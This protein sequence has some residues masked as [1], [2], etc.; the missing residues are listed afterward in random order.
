[1][2]R[3][4]S[5]RRHP[6]RV[7]LGLALGLAVVIIAVYQPMLGFDFVSFDDINNVVDNPLLQDSLTPESAFSSFTEAGPDGLWTPL[8][9]VSYLA[10]RSLFGPGPFGFH[11]TNLL[12]F[13]AACALFFLVLREMTG[14]TVKSLLAAALFALHPLRVESVAWITE[15]K[16]CLLLLFLVLSLAAYHRWIRTG[17]KEWYAGLI[18]CFLLGLLSKPTMVMLPFLLLALDFWPQGRIG[19]HGPAPPATW[20]RLVMEKLPLLAL[21]LVFSAVTLRA[22]EGNL[23]PLPLPERLAMA[24]SSPIIYLGKTAWPAGLHLATFRPVMTPAWWLGLGA[25]AVLAGAAW[26]SFRQRTALPFL[27]AGWSWYLLALVPNSGIVPN[28]T[29]WLADRFTLLPHLLLFPALVWSAAP[30]FERRPERGWAA[31]ALAGAVLLALAAVSLHQLPVWRDSVSLWSRSVEIAPR[32]PEYRQALGTSLARRGE[33][34]KGIEQ[35]QVALAL[36][37]DHDLA[38]LNLGLILERQGRKE[39]AISHYRLAIRSSPRSLRARFYLAETLLGLGRVEAALA[40]YRE[41][42]AV[43]KG[44]AEEAMALG[45]MA[46]IV[47]DGSRARDFYWAAARLPCAEPESAALLPQLL[48]PEGPAAGGGR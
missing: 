36:D 8:T 11:L 7:P 20:K 15:R 12:L 1:M 33:L 18:L 14:G 38:N 42:A 28:G 37:P 32:D 48:A 34:E 3:P 23:H 40:A 19:A 21:S 17:K 47:G 41:L 39:E 24:F 6:L 44:Y 31:V 45:R 25:G 29:Q 13:A 9:W 30:W 16:D 10:D 46:E 5:A 22:Q 35:L 43:F 27:L 26:W 2:S 4:L